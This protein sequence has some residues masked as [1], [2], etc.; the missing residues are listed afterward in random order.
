MDVVDRRNIL[1]QFKS[2]E[3]SLVGVPLDLPSDVDENSL[4]HLCNTLL[5][6]VSMQSLAYGVCV[7]VVLPQ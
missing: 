2:D 4:G 1:A 5:Q 7:C 3:G 6:N